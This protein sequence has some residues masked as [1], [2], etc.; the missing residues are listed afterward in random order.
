[1]SIALISACWDRGPKDPIERYVLV[2]LADNAS[3]EGFAYPSIETLANKTQMSERTILRKLR[4]LEAGGWVE[5]NRRAKSSSYWVLRSRLGLPDLP[6][7]LA[8][9]SG[10]SLKRNKSSDCVSLE[11]NKSSDCVSLEGN[12]SSDCVSLEGNKSSDCVSVLGDTVSM[13]GDTVS[14]PP[15]PLKGVTVI[16]RQE[17][18]R[19]AI[20][21]SIRSP[22]YDFNSDPSTALPEGMEPTQYAAIVLEQCS[23]P[24]SAYVLSQCRQAIGFLAKEKKLELHEAA[25][26]I[27]G[28]A[29]DAKLRGEKVNGFWFGSDCGWQQD[30]AAQRRSGQL[31]VNA[32]GEEFRRRTREQHEQQQHRPNGSTN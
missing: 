11:G 2:A 21:P 16:N 32:A 13:L 26:L 18:S 6:R 9:E 14:K 4:S 10:M 8:P 15:D 3:D 28:R 27:I 5:V 19:E 23:I 22:K 30:G 1:M 7:R 29:L 12:K 25:Q 31:G 24:N 20:S 17:P